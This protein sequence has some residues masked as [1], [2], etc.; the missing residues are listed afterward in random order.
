MADSVF[1]GVSLA[2][3]PWVALARVKEISSPLEEPKRT[4]TGLNGK[5]PA[6]TLVSGNARLFQ[7]NP[8][9]YDLRGALG[10]LEE[11]E[12]PVS[13][14]AKEIGIEDWVYLWEAGRPGASRKWRRSARPLAR[15]RSSGPFSMDADAFAGD[16]LRAGLTVLGVIEPA[17]PRES[18]VSSLELRAFG[19]LRCSCGTTFR[20][21]RD[22]WQAGN[23]SVLDCAA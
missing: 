16:R 5:S 18:I 15:R 8:A 20:L 19:V 7:S 21:S 23:G 3:V 14:Y 4:R 13:R 10:S 2:Q 11:Q 22:Q 12:G 6:A 17:I 1:F 9:L